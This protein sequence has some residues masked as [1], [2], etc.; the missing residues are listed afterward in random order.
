M[1]VVEAGLRRCRGGCQPHA[2]GVRRTA[3]LAVEM[4]VWVWVRV[5]VRVVRAEGGG[6][7]G[8]A[9]TALVGEVL[10]R[11]E[12]AGGG[13]KLPGGG[14]VRGAEEGT[15]RTH[16]SSSHVSLSGDQTLGF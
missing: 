12:G 16:G 13:D 4:R 7:V 14:A 2:Q 11:A 6:G 15:D 8:A 3:R 10:R 9:R 5:G 1:V